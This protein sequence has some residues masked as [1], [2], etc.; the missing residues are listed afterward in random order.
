VRQI[1]E[2][3]DR[4]VLVTADGG[5]ISA[6]AA[7]VASNSP[8]NCLR[9]HRKRDHGCHEQGKRREVSNYLSVFNDLKNNEIYL[10]ALNLA[11]RFAA[12]QQVINTMI[13]HMVI[14]IL[15]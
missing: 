11:N 14:W 5:K 13:F 1:E 15:G 9:P 3:E 2:Q 6:Q 8:I 7:V 4:S 12:P 10:G